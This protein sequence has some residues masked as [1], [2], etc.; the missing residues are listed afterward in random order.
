MA[1]ARIVADRMGSLLLDSG[2]DRPVEV[3]GIAGPVVEIAKLTVCRTWR[4][5]EDGEQYVVR[6]R[7]EHSFR[8][9]FCA[10]AKTR[11]SPACGGQ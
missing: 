8:A 9:G 4:L 3:E 6:I 1:G 10:A 7:C 2:N 5:Q 11:K